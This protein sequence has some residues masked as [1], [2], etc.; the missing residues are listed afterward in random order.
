[1]GRRIEIDLSNQIGIHLNIDDYGLLLYCAHVVNATE[2][3]RLYKAM[4]SEYYYRLSN[5]LPPVNEIDED[6]AYLPLN[7]LPLVIEFIDTQVL[8]YLNSLAPDLNLPDQWGIIDLKIDSFLTNQ[9]GIFEDFVVD[10]IALDIITVD[11]YKYIFTALRNF[12]QQAVTLNV[13]Y[14]VIIT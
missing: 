13:R 14:T 9:G 6:K 1:M 11:D 3:L 2:A 12:F 4:K 7:E 10:D 8:Q 5:N